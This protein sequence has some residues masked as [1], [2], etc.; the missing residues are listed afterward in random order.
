VD[1]RLR[2]EQ[3]IRERVRAPRTLTKA[4][5]PPNYTGVLLWRYAKIGQM[6]T[7]KDFLTRQREYYR[8]RPEEW[9]NHWATTYEPSDA[10][11]ARSVARPIA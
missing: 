4:E 11:A 3:D 6:R 8:T 5:W 7:H 10:W 2:D 9:I 1:A